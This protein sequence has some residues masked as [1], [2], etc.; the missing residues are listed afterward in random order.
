VLLDD[1]ELGFRV[2]QGELLEVGD[3]PGGER[4]LGVV[5]QAPSEGVLPRGG[6]LVPGL[7]RLAT[8]RTAAL[9]DVR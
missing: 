5:D 8:P 3:A 4:V 9:R 1:L 6:R 2:E 7:R